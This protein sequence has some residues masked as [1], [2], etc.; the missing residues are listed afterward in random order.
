MNYR[1][2]SKREGEKYSHDLRLGKKGPVLNLNNTIETGI[3]PTIYNHK[4]LNEE[5][6]RIAKLTEIVTEFKF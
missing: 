1:L 5:S 4:R 2:I 6:L 3:P